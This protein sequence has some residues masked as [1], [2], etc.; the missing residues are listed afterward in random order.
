MIRP[1]NRIRAYIR[2]RF[3]PK[4]GA[5]AVPSAHSRLSCRSS[6]SDPGAIRR[7]VLARRAGIW[8]Y[9]RIRG[10]VSFCRKTIPVFPLASVGNDHPRLSRAPCDP[11]GAQACCFPIG[12]NGSIAPRS[13]NKISSTSAAVDIAATPGRCRSPARRPEAQHVQDRQKHNAA[14]IRLATSRAIDGSALVSQ[15][16]SACNATP[17]TGNTS[18]CPRLYP[19]LCGGG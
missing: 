6:E 5:T 19:P 12:W 14:A 16:Q 11:T 9:P 15:T 18:S 3:S 10:Q 7:R 1:P 8:A 2:D 13:E 17:T 4:S